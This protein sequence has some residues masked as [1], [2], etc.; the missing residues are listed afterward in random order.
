MKR[1]FAL[2]CLL[3]LIFTGCAGTDSGM[4]R[5]MAL[6]AK[7][8]ASASAFDAVVTADYGD[9]TCTFTMQCSIDKK[10]KL[11]FSV[12]EPESISGISGIVSSEG[13]KLTFD[14]Q[15]L[16]FPLLAEDQVTP[17]SA[18]WVLFRSLR[19]GYL[20]SCGME[21]GKLR[22]A[23]D[24]SYEKNA[25]H[26]EVWLSSDDIPQRCEIYWQGRRLLSIDVKN[27]TFL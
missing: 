19:A 9:K 12:T 1:I 16:S 5:A 15:A 26:L 8:L 14:D 24:D 2:L 10:G 7:L 22:L 4:E 6:R 13:G 18:P 20:T 21:S 25:L 17:V 23:I 3:A 27:F 11:T